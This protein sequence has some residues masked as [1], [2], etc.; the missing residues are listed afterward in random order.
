M[1]MGKGRGEAE[2][3]PLLVLISLLSTKDIR[4]IGVDMESGIT[5]MFVSSPLD[6]GLHLNGANPC[7][8]PSLAANLTMAI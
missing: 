2:R 3:R 4:S 1:Q 8:V 7:P 6:L 5:R